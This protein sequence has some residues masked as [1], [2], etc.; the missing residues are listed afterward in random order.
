MAVHTVYVMIGDDG[1]HVVTLTP[2][3]P[4]TVPLP[5]APPACLVTQWPRSR[6]F[7]IEFD[8]PPVLPGRPLTEQ[9]FEAWL[10]GLPNGSWSAV[11]Q[12]DPSRATKPLAV[13][14]AD[15]RVL[16]RVRAGQPLE[17]E[18]ENIGG[19]TIPDVS[20]AVEMTWETPQPNQVRGISTWVAGETLGLARCD[21]PA[22]I[23]PNEVARFRL[24]EMFYDSV[25]SAVASLSPERYRLVVK[26]GQTVVGEMPGN[27]LGAVV[28]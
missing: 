27:E 15:A 28:N 13:P 20:V 10:Y 16:V 8:G 23:P 25:A 3:E 21:G 14:P 1:S 9:E 6:W 11:P 7:H 26:S 17:A 19:E 5:G 18:V 22:D 4:E 12:S 24:P 2:P